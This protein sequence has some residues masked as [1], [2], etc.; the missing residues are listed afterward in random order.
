MVQWPTGSELSAEG[1]VGALAAGRFVAST[2]VRIDS[3]GVSEDGKSISIMSNAER[4]R[5]IVAGG[6]VAAITEGGSGTLAVDDIPS[7]E[8]VAWLGFPDP[9]AAIYVR[10]ECVGNAGACAWSQPFVVERRASLELKQSLS[11]PSARP[12]R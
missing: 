12:R 10:I 4:L 3:V 6:I 11:Q 8:R 7:L 9:G 5:W 1:I 2:G